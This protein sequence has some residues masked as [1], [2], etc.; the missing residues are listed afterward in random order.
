MQESLLWIL[1]GVF[2]LLLAVIVILVRKKY[3]RPTDYYSFFAIGIFWAVAGMFLFMF[4]QDYTFFVIGFLL[5]TFGFVHRD[6]WK[7]NR[8]KWK[9]LKR[10]EKLVQIILVIFLAFIIIAG[11]VSMVIKV[12]GLI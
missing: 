8:V 9:N 11:I 12:K 3:P 1:I 7:K 4:N 6:K 10:L 5:A 2:I